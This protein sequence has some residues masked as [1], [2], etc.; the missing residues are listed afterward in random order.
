M[1]DFSSNSE[2][3]VLKSTLESNL[4]TVEVQVFSDNT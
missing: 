2:I 4:Q 3:V 1:I